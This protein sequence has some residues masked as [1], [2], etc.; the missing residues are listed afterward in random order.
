MSILDQDNEGLKRVW[1]WIKNLENNSKHFVKGSKDYS[2]EGLYS[3]VESSIRE[4]GMLS[5]TY[6]FRG[7]FF[8]SN[9]F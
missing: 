5:V 6:L 3:I 8:Q 1:S 4:A 7:Q 9:R 2:R